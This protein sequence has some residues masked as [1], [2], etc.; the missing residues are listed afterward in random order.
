MF[1]ALGAGSASAAMFHL[2]TH[3][4][5]K[6]LIFLG[7][8]VI[9]HA[10]HT[11]DMR[12]MGGLARH[13]PVTTATFTIGS[14]ALAGFPPLSGFFSKD[15]ILALL[16]HEGHPVFFGIVVLASGITAFYMT[17]LWFRVFAGPEQTES[18]TR[19][20]RP[21]SRRWWCWRPS[22]WSL[23]SALTLRG[24]ARA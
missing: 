8:G 10:A 16:L 3:A 24:D 23:V 1:I 5:F 9:I 20:T 22:R 2:T 15:E 17:R 4:F 13:L 18:F 6:S 21:W 7:A 11:Q 12:E 14:L 19:G